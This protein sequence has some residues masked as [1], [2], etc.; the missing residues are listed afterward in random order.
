[1]GF[2]DAGDVKDAN[3]EDMA[4]GSLPVGG[5]D[6]IETIDGCGEAA[7]IRRDGGFC[8][9]LRMGKGWDGMGGDGMGWDGQGGREV[10]GG[11]MS[12]WDVVILERW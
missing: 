7:R 10:E 2:A 3:V 9:R 4:G 5:G 1:M 8:H 6:G 12:E 11:G